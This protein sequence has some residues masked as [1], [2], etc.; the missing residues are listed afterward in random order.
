MGGAKPRAAVE[1]LEAFAL[2]EVGA[3]ASAAAVL[4]RRIATG[5]E[6]ESAANRFGC[7]ISNL[8]IG[9]N[10]TAVDGAG[11]EAERLG[12]SHAMTSSNAP[13]GLAEEVAAGIQGLSSQP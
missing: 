11:I 10:A 9:N 3:G 1:V 7:Q 5:G 12:Y 2:T 4:Q 13:E 6:L 8:L